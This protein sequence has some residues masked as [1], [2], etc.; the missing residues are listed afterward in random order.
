MDGRDGTGHNPAPAYDALSFGRYLKAIRLEAGIT[1]EAVAATTRIPPGVLRSL[2]AED[3]ARLPDEVYMKGFLR[4]YAEVLALDPDDIIRRYQAD[5]RL[6]RR[7]ARYHADL[8]RSRKRFWFKMMMGIAALT[9]LILLSTAL[10]GPPEQ[11]KRGPPSVAQP[12]AMVL[13][14]PKFLRPPPPPQHHSL[15]ITAMADT[16][17]KVIIDGQ[18]PRKYSLKTGERIT[19]KA[20]RYFNLL[21]GNAGAIT[22]VFDHKPLPQPGKTG[23]ITTLWLPRHHGR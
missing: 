3:H 7:A 13:A 19:L 6:L 2:E 9:C 17:I 21:M 10:M 4:S 23:Q 20:T 11:G 15:V 5:C 12:A 1:L 16:W 22:L 14:K 8:L 18:M